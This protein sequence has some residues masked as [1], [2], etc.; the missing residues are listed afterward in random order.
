MGA[1]IVFGEKMPASDSGGGVRFGPGGSEFGL[2]VDQDAHD[3]VQALG[4]GSM[5]QLSRS[6]G[7]NTK[8]VWVN[9]S[10]V[11]YVTEHE[12]VVSRGADDELPPLPPEQEPEFEAE[13]PPAPIEA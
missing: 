9:P 7:D 3:V 1:F 10:S 6:R 2:V 13:A 11:L 12:E 4:V 5:V 8:A